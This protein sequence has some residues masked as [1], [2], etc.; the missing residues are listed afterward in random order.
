M[1]QPLTL[2]CSSKTISND[3]RWTQEWLQLPQRLIR[4]LVNSMIHR[5]E[6]FIA[7]RGDFRLTGCQSNAVLDK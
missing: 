7:V 2:N 1:G 4:T 5:C 6:S 3:R